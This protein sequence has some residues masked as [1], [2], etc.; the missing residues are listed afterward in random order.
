MNVS[1]QDE[2]QPFS[3]E[4]Q[5]YVTPVFLEELGFVKRKHKFSGADLATICI[6]VS[7]RVASDPLVRLCSRLYAATG[8]LLSPEGLNK[9]LNT[10]AVFLLQ[11]IFSLLLQQKV[12]E[13][14]QISKHLFSYFQRIHIV[15]ATVFQVPNTLENTYPGSGGCAKTTGIKIQLE[16]NLHSG[17]FLNFQVGPGEK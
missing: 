10:K 7:Q 13:Q 6:W 15:N 17:E 12:C 5:R 8:T 2:L 14:A 4:L 1:F 16:Y 3:E 9:R 11:H